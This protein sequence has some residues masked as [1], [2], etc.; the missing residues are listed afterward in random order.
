VIINEAPIKYSLSTLI[1]PPFFLIS[2]NTI[3]SPSPVPLS[4]YFVVKNGSKTLSKFSFFIP[5]PVSFTIIIILSSTSSNEI[6]IFPSLTIESLA[7]DIKLNR[8]CF[9]DSL[10]KYISHSFSL[11]NSEIF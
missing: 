1:V 2:L 7:F 4:G 11:K 9:K 5:F 3:L 8:I 6:I 10:L